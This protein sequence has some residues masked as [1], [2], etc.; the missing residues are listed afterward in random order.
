MGP[1][2]TGLEGWPK[3]SSARRGLPLGWWTFASFLLP[4]SSNAHSVHRKHGA[5]T[6]TCLYL[7]QEGIGLAQAEQA[8]FN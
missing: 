7:F 1:L 8:D 3:R 6:F 5:L 4:A 2:V